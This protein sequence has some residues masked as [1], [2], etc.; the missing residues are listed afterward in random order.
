[1]NKTSPHLIENLHV[2]MQF[3]LMVFDDGFEALAH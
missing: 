2:F 1:M 3:V